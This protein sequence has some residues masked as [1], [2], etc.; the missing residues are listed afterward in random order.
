MLGFII[1]IGIIYFIYYQVTKKETVLCQKCHEEI[2]RRVKECPYCGFKNRFKTGY[3]RFFEVLFILMA[4][5]SVITPTLT[6]KPVMSSET[7]VKEKDD[8]QVSIPN[9]IPTLGN[10]SPSFFSILSSRFCFIVLA[11][12]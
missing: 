4:I 2:G 8:A 1:I 6:I 3:D 11:S 12:L 9:M 7:T 5:G 10:S